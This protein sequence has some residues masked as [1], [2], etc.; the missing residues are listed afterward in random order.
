MLSLLFWFYEKGN[1]KVR[2]FFYRGH[3]SYRNFPQLNA[4]F[5]A[6]YLQTKNVACEESSAFLS[7]TIIETRIKRITRMKVIVSDQF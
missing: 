6:D 1:S 4:R 5:E 2:Y 7:A 3:F